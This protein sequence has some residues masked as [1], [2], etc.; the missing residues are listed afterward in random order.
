MSDCTARRADGTPCQAHA[1][2]DSEFCFT[3][4]P[5]RRNEREIARRSGGLARAAQV[6]PDNPTQSRI[7]TAGDVTSLLSDI[8]GQILR[9]ELDSRTANAVGYL[10]NVLLKSIQVGESEE[11]LARLE[12]S[13]R[14]GAVLGL[15]AFEIEEPIKL[16][17][18]DGLRQ[19]ALSWN[20][21]NV[22]SHLSRL[23]CI[24]TLQH[25]KLGPLS[26][27]P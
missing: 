20:A 21:S 1:V 9:G 24:S 16:R 14:P 10:C 4:H 2:T 11:R 13:V 15:E 3:H 18:D 23:C 26:S 5:D 25:S 19:A 6:L 7:R 22:P 12:M 8:I 27:S 17:A